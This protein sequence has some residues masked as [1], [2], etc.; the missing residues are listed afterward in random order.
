MN[1]LILG[2]VIYLLVITLGY[3]TALFIGPARNLGPQLVALW[4]RYG[5]QNF[6]EGWRAYGPWGAALSR[7]NWWVIT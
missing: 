7:A 2:L 1:A 5:T 3:N 4:A 6:T